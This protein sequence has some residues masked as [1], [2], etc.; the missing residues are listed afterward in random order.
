MAVLPSTIFRLRTAVT[1]DTVEVGNQAKTPKGMAPITHPQLSTAVARA[2]NDSKFL[3]LL[4]FFFFTHIYLG[5]V[6]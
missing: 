5:W 2:S 1:V 4:I 6:L 3:G